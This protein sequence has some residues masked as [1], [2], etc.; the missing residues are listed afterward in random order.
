MAAVAASGRG[1]PAAAA[2]LVELAIGLG[3]DTPERR[4]RAADHHIHA[5]DLPHAD[6]L[7]DS[8]VAACRAA[9]NGPGH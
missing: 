4:I 8:V 7:L 6:A 1:A 5:G 3:G 9:Q 2:E